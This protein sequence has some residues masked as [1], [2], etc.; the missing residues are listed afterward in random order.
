MSF[1]SLTV[2]CRQIISLIVICGLMRPLL[3]ASLRWSPH[4][5]FLMLR[6][7]DLAAVWPQWRSALTAIWLNKRTQ[8]K[9]KKGRWG[10]GKI[11]TEK[12]MAA[13]PGVFMAVLMKG[14]YFSQ[15]KGCRK[16]ERLDFSRSHLCMHGG[17]KHTHTHTSLLFAAHLYSNVTSLIGTE[18][19]I[20][21]NL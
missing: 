7:K 12:E 6:H 9:G 18:K 14:Y 10:V 2:V 19:K 8:E 1:K 5:N 21:N 17:K 3:S 16:G 20:W 4:P 15:L 13:T 11:E